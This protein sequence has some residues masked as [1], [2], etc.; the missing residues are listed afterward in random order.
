MKKAE[1]ILQYQNLISEPPVTPKQLYAQSCAND[2]VTVETWR[3]TWVSQVAANKE[4]VGSFKDRGIGKF[5]GKHKYQ[6]V[7]VAGSGPSLKGNA[8]QLKDRG[9]MI[10]ISCLHNFHYLEDMGARPDYYVSLD[11]GPVVLEEVSEGGSRSP[12]EYW[13]LTKDR[14]LFAYIGSHPD[15]IRK[16]K[17]EI[18][19]FTCA[20]PATDVEAEIKAIEPFH[21]VVS[22]G[23]NVLGAAMYIAKG[24]FGASDIIYVGADFCF[25]Y[26]HK[27][28]AWD[29]KYDKDLGNCVWLT[30]VYGIRRLTWQ[31]YANFKG[32]FDY[33]SLRVPGI[34]TNASEGGCLGS[35]PYGN[36]SSFRYMDL[37]DVFKTYNLHEHVRATAEDPE[38]DRKIVLF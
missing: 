25:S 33:V 24:Y 29:S 9:D 34:W 7:I 31:S 8:A 13:E 37:S 10:L 3:K 22:C 38:K 1:V 6:P 5:F 16:W 32:W 28:H 2:E 20:L 14:T 27:F 26:D 30:D 23:G 15:L 4:T 35:Y 36:L 18:Y 19:F 17:G 21:Q 12:E 11:A